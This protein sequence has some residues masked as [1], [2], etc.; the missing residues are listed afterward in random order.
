MTLSYPRRAAH[1][2]DGQRPELVERETPIRPRVD[3]LLNAVEFGV[4]V[5]VVGLLP[6]LGPLERD[7]VGVEDLAEPFATHVHNSVGVVS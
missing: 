4:A 5:R 6:R 1:G 2:A 7:V 3:D